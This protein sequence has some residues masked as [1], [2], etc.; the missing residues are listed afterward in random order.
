MISAL[1]DV[2][3]LTLNEDH[4]FMVV[5]CDGIWY[6]WLLMYIIFP[7]KHLFTVVHI[8]GTLE[9]QYSYK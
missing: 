7:S 6:D 5:A 9:S 8:P 1:P 3:V 2:K 4:D